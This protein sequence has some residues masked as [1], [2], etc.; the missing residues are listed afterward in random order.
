MLSFGMPTL[1]LRQFDI[2]DA[3]SDG[4]AIEIEGRATG[5][6]SWLLTIMKLSTLTTLRLE[7]DR[8][9]VVA[10][11]LSGEIH[12]VIPL[13]AI[14]STQCGYSKA[15][16]LLA[17]AFVVLAIGLSTGELAPFLLSL[18]VAVAFGAAYFFSDKMFIS[19]SAGDTTVAIAYKKS[20][21]EGTQIDL[22]RTL[23]AIQ[24][25]N[26]KIIQGRS[27]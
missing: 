5:F 18:L 8:V 24:L 25:I 20:A 2:N 22:E 13:G 1:V 26:Q 14:D 7:S 4:P 15:I 11:G 3:T 23:Q 21:I 19:V 12:T 27:G 10:P 16:S 9:S 6:V 17:A